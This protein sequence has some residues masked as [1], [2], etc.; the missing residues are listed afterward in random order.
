MTGRGRS[1]SHHRRTGRRASLRLR[2]H[3]LRDRSLHADGL[4]ARCE[5]HGQAGPRGDAQKPG[6]R[7]CRRP[8]PW[9]RGGDGC[10]RARG[11]RGRS[12]RRARE[13]SVR[14]GSHLGGLVVDPS[15]D[16]PAALTAVSRADA[17][18]A[19]AAVP[20]GEVSRPVASREQP[21]GTAAAPDEPRL[22]E[23]PAS[24]AQL[25]RPGPVLS[26]IGVAGVL[27]LVLAIAAGGF[28]LGHAR[29]SKPTS[30]RAGTTTGASG[31][32]RS[33]RSG[34]AAGYA[35]GRRVGRR[36]AYSAAFQTGYRQ[37]RAQAP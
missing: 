11:Q 2:R 20:F 13:G 31:A 1:P 15:D 27:V 5:R 28:A 34:Y 22:P 10:R 16:G 19:A 4:A 29:P 21:A 12:A 36:R 6:R 33:E 8:P 17:L 35:E 9:A 37:G 30:E 3:R 26:R 7:L 18:R 25:P 23:R 24:A 14:D 32:P